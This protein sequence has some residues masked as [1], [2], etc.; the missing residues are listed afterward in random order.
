MLALVYLITRETVQTQ[1]LGA[2]SKPPFTRFLIVLYILLYLI[3]SV[4]FA[5]FTYTHLCHPDYFAL[6]VLQARRNYNMII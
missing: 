3:V 1:Q 5:F 4:L 2:D 6:G